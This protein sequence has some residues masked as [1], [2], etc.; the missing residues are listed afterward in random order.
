M[1]TSY[2]RLWFTEA[3]R[4]YVFDDNMFWT[5]LSKDLG[6]SP[7]NFA[8]PAKAMEEYDSYKTSLKS[9][10]LNAPAA[11]LEHWSELEDGTQNLIW[12]EILP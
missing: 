11:A 3:K 10:G 4:W 8:H 5:E 9:L 12:R 6:S 7:V 2:Y 1:G